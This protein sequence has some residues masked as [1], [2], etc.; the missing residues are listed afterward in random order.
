M[1]LETG[2]TELLL[3]PA[4][5]LAHEGTAFVIVKLEI[6]YHAEMRWPGEVIIGTSVEAV[7]RSSCTLRQALFQKDRCVAAARSVI[8]LMDD[9]TRKSC[10]LS[11]SAVTRLKAIQD[12]KSESIGDGN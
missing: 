9:Q 10:P 4:A 8:V 5:P 7:G 12:L 11:P 3:N 2:R 6:E 1:A